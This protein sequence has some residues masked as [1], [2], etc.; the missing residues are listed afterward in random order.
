MCHKDRDNASEFI[1]AYHGW[2]YSIDGD[3]IAPSFGRAYG[4]SM[5]QED[6]ALTPLERVYSYR[7]LI[8][9]SS[10]KDGVSLKEHLGKTK[11]LIDFVIDRSPK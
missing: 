7:G 4:S 10:T 5:R 9:I 2:T 1:C 8:F 11:E 3:L 6:F